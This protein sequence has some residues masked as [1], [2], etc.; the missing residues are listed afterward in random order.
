MSREQVALWR[1]TGPWAAIDASE[2]ASTRAN[3]PTDPA[4]IH[5]LKIQSASRTTG[6]SQFISADD[7]DII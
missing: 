6:R 4:R 1:S 2:H 3:F 7:H 5:R